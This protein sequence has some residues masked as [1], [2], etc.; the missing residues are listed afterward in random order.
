MAKHGK[1][2][3]GPWMLQETQREP[4][5]LEHVFNYM[6]WLSDSS[7]KKESALQVHQGWAIRGAI[8]NSFIFI[9]QSWTQ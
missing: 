6:S 3:F 5:E 9:N 2:T 7:L 8:Y 4:L 1:T